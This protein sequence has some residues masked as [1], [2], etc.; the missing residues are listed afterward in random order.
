MN[1]LVLRDAQGG[2]AWLT[3]DSPV[4]HYGCPVLRISAE[5]VLG[6]FGPADMIDTSGDPERI[7]PDRIITAADVVV[8]WAMKPDRTPEEKAA[9]R[10][11]L[12]QWPEGP[13]IGETGEREPFQHA[14]L[15]GTWARLLSDGTLEMRDP[16]DGQD[17][18][19]DAKCRYQY[20]VLGGVLHSR[21]LPPQAV[22]DV[23]RGADGPGPFTPVD[24]WPPIPGI[25]D[26]FWRYH[27][28]DP[29][30]F[31]LDGARGIGADDTLPME[32]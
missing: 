21:R 3:T 9:A 17:P 13:Q 23:W 6:D 30:R 31:A 26:A 1:H 32:G 14:H 29:V 11:F 25:L 12:R 19:P 22:G 27:G 8:G 10:K 15:D 2:E 18:D 4:S 20:R 5:D 7:H 24:G 28:G 16:N